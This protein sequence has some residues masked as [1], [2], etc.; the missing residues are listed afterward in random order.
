MTQIDDR[1]AQQPNTEAL[2]LVK[3][4][5]VKRR[6][7]LSP[8]G[9]VALGGAG[10]VLLT[11]VGAAAWGISSAANA[12]KNTP[13]PDDHA[14]SATSSPTPEASAA[15]ASVEGDPSITIKS[16]ELSGELSQEQLAQKTIDDLSK[17][18]M[19]GANEDAY[20][21]AEASDLNSYDYSTTIALKNQ[22]IFA[23]AIFGANWASNPATKNTVDGFTKSNAQDITLWL[24]THDEPAP[25]RFNISYSYDSFAPVSASSMNVV[26]TSNNNAKDNRVG[27]EIQPDL[28][29]ANG[30]Q[31]TAHITYGKSGGLNYI[32]SYSE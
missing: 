21:G 11:G 28:K 27:S 2:P 23:P 32:T 8:G 12:P 9:Y 10:L 20:K 6:R 31:F 19:A 7:K 26:Y 30:D 29:Q 15:P 17:W 5:E 14:S 25:K 3:T 13:E 22:A 1:P 18:R 4:P 16:L 24:A